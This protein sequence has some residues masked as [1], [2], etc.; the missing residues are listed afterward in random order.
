MG[1]GTREGATDAGTE[2]LRRSER[3]DNAAFHKASRIV[4]TLPSRD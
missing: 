4:S 3:Y 1:L 2:Q